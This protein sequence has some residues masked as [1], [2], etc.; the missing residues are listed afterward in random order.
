MFW[1]KWAGLPWA[2]GADPRG[3]QGA[4]CF[5]TAQAAREELGLPWPSDRMG[6]WY[7]RARRGDWVGLRCDWNDL[8]E[9]IKEPEA[10]A[11]LRLENATGGFGVGVLVEPEIVVTVRHQG[12][13]IIAP[14][15]PLGPLTLYQLK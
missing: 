15:K 6:D 14:R 4:C 1:R 12:R 8:T 10:G 7:V 2:W 11:L 9:P 3:G 13:L 5:R